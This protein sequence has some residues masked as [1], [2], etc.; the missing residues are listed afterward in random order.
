MYLS[1]NINENRVLLSG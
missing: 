1:E